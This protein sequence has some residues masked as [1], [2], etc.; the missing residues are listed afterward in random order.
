MSTTNLFLLDVLAG[1][2]TV[3]AI[4]CMTAYR[5]CLR[6]GT[7]MRYEI[8]ALISEHRRSQ[9]TMADLRSRLES[10]AGAL[11]EIKRERARAVKP[12]TLYPDVIG[13][14]QLPDDELR[15]DRFDESRRELAAGEYTESRPYRA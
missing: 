14:A 3:L 8:D 4:L 6:R 5:H 2:L 9:E 1:P 11:D 13:Y 7:A 12:K 10:A 15:E